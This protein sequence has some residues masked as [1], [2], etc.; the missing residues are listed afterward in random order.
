[1]FLWTRVCVAVH[2]PTLFAIPADQHGQ[3]VYLPLWME[4]KN[5]NYLQNENRIFFR[6]HLLLI[7]LACLLSP[8]L[9]V[10]CRSFFVSWYRYLL[11]CV[12][13]SRSSIQVIL[14][15][16]LA[17]FLQISVPTT[18]KHLNHRSSQNFFSACQFLPH[19]TVVF[20]ITDSPA[21]R[22]PKIFLFVTWSFQLIFSIHL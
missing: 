18:A 10:L 13:C 6:C 20:L 21:C 8:C 1:M 17:C 15:F 22:F 11:F 5:E 9:P 14:G 4:Y 7:R 16:P 12:H 19:I 2:W 3:H